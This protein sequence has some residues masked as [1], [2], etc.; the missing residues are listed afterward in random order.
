MRYY[1][2]MKIDAIRT[3]GVEA[4]NLEEAM[5]KAEDIYYYDTKFEDLSEVNEEVISVEDQEGNCYYEKW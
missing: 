3:I 1:V 5:E 2:T 4:G